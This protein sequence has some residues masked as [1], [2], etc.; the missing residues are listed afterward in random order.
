MGRA[1]DVFDDI[2]GTPLDRVNGPVLT[3]LNR[4]W[5]GS[6]P[7]YPEGGGDGAKFYQAIGYTFVGLNGTGAPMNHTGHLLH[8]EVGGGPTTVVGTTPFGD[9][10]ATYLS[11]MWGL[12]HQGPNGSPSPRPLS[13]PAVPGTENLR[14]AP[15]DPGI[16]PPVIDPNGLAGKGAPR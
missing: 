4:E 2:N 13:G 3:E 14:L 7:K 15:P 10:L 1:T 8:F 16:T 9:Q 5:K 11:T 12:P 6:G